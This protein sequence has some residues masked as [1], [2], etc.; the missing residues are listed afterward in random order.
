MLNKLFNNLTTRSNVFAVWVTVGF[1]DVTD[2]TVRPVKLGAEVGKAEGRNVRHRMFAIIDRT[3]L[4][5]W[6]TVDPTSPTGVYT[7]QSKS[8]ITTIKD[9]V[10]GNPLKWTI[11]SKPTGAALEW[12]LWLSGAPNPALIGVRAV[13]TTPLPSNPYTQRQWVIQPG[14]VL[15]IDPDTDNEETVTVQGTPTAPTVT[16]TRQ[17]ANGA[18]VISRG[19]PGPWPRYDPR[20]DPGVVPYFAIID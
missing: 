17:H 11:V 20:K 5:V 1:F 15:T 14:S 3:N 6:P 7:V 18:V 10:T 9:P 16:F 19:N 2:D 13:P 12:N 4:Q 8:D